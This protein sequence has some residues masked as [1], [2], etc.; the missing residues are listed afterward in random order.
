MIHTNYYQTTLKK[1]GVYAMTNENF[2]KIKD[3]AIIF[4]EAPIEVR[5]IP[6]NRGEVRELVVHPFFS[7]RIVRFVEDTEQ[8]YHDILSDNASLQKAILRFKGLIEKSESTDSILMLLNESYRLQ[9]LN[10]IQ[11]GLSPDEM[12]RLLADVWVDSERP[13]NDVIPLSTI[14]KWFK[15][16]SKQ[17]LMDADEFAYYDSLP[18]KFTV[19][20]GI[21]SESN[22]KGISYTLSLEKAEWFANRFQKKGYVLTGTAKKKDVLAYF[23][24]RE[25]QEILIEPKKI[26]SLHKM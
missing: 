20:R 8:P 15:N 10:I 13:N 19:Y 25:E 11:K 3:T 16:A 2:R 18:D 7:S 26:A 6:L 5:K 17:S 9:F 23:N 14:I 21:G 4:L 22:K 1:G 12:G 24:R